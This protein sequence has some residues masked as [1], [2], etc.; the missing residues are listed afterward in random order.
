[1]A[2]HVLDYVLALTRGT[3]VHSP[4][5]LPFLRE[6]ITWGAGP[7]AGQ[8]LVLGAKAHAAIE[9]RNHVSIE[10]VRA[11]AHPVLRHRIVTNFSAAAE[12][13]TPDK[14]IDRLLVEVDPSAAVGAGLPG[15]R[16]AG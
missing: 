13:M 16:T 12:G 7:R 3:R 6:W 11:V 5:P 9:G 2:D 8:F 1:V 10:D 4:E 14:I 15:I